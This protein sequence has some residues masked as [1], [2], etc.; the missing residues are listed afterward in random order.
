MRPQ[1][2][3]LVKP[4]RAGMV[5]FYL[6]QGEILMLFMIPSNPAFGGSSPQIA[7]GGIDPGEDY[8]QAAVREAGEELGLKRSNIVGGLIGP[9]K[10]QLKSQSGENYGI[11]VLA[12]QVKSVDNFNATDFETGKTLWLTLEQFNSIG[13]AEQRSVVQKIHS[14]ILSSLKSRT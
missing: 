7:K 3:K 2:T 6:D 14:K 1:S 4:P 10:Q 12:C 13:R 5:P 9:V 8:Q 11:T